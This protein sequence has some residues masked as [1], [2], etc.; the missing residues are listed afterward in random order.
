MTDQSLLST[1]LGILPQMPESTILRL[2]IETSVQILDAD[3]GSLLVY[4]APSKSLRFA[5][6]LGDEQSA[7]RLEGQ[8]VPI[9]EGLV[10]LAAVTREVQV[11][12]PIFHD[13]QQTQK[14]SGE[15]GEPEA[16]IAAP[17]V[18]NDAL[19]GVLTAVSFRPGK[20]FS[21]DSARLY[22]RAATI[23]ALIIDQRRR[24]AAVETKDREQLSSL[25]MSESARAE[26]KIFESIG[27]IVN[28]N[29]AALPHLVQMLNAF[30]ALVSLRTGSRR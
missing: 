18:V 28:G 9:G 21:A 16:V 13:L 8:S 22:A 17:M 6:T 5:M 11:G 2:L 26:Q 10:G 4:D 30:E 15:K 1:Y 24:L 23:A 29:P 25:A 27:K 7:S 19:I 12:A 14:R 20:R 3:E